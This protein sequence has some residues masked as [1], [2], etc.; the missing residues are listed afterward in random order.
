VVGVLLNMLHLVVEVPVVEVHIIIQVLVTMVQ[1]V[2]EPVVLQ[3]TKIFH[4]NVEVEEEVVLR[5][6]LILKMGGM[7]YHQQLQGLQL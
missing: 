6:L 5:V 3:D 4:L 1:L 2:R 7:V